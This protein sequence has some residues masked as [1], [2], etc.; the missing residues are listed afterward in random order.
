MG[1]VPFPTAS[2]AETIAVQT[3][4]GEYRGNVMTQVHTPFCAVP[5]VGAAAVQL[6]R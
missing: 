3:P 5:E 4:D 1:N 2:C 6:C